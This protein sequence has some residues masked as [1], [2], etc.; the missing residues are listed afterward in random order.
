MLTV[1]GTNSSTP[2]IVKADSEE[3]ARQIHFPTCCY[4]KPMRRTASEGL[5]IVLAVRN[6]LHVV[7]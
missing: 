1:A 2:D 6:H 7:L 4:W 5:V 3:A